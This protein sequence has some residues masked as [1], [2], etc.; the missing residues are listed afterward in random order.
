MASIRTRERQIGNLEQFDIAFTHPDGR[1]VRSDREGLPPYSFDRAARGNITVAQW[2]D[3]RFCR[4]YPGF[5]VAVFDGNGNQV[6]GNM[7][8]QN[9]RDSYYED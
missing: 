7:L 6:A 5:D 8:L 1:D 2:R 9:V 3:Q 4:V